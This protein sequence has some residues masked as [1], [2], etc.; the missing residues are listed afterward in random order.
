ME[1]IAPRNAVPF[2]ERLQWSHRLS[3]METSR[4]SAAVFAPGDASMEPPPFGY[5]NKRADKGR[6]VLYL[7]LQWSH[8][9][10]AMETTGKLTVLAVM[11][12]LLPW[13]HRLSAMETLLQSGVH[14]LHA[15][16]SMGLPP[17]GDG[18]RLM[19]GPVRGP[20]LASMGLPPFGD[21]NEGGLGILA[22]V[23]GLQ[24]GHRLSVMETGTFQVA[25]R[26]S[27]PASMEPPAF[28][29]GNGDGG[30]AVRTGPH[31]ASMEP[32]PFGDGN[33]VTIRQLSYIPTGFNGATAFRRWKHGTLVFHV[34]SEDIASMESPPF[35]DGN[36][37]S[38]P[39]LRSLCRSLNGATAFRRWKPVVP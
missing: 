4:I 21:G 20:F 9:L 39:D 12:R 27:D 6:L 34:D 1:T 10:S 22:P 19:R 28:G 2:S 18:N 25:T 36:P 11:T 14:R 15:G 8:R 35:G 5:G 17:F 7:K 13:S 32:P 37:D 23:I 3:A 30:C 33:E 26:A 24:W 38:Q 29:D 16:A 31:P